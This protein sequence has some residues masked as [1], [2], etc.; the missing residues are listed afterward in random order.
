MEKKD[1][2]VSIKKI[3][4]DLGLSMTTVSRAISGKGRIG[5]RTVARVQEYIEQNALVPNVHAGNQ[6]AAYT[7]TIC[8]ALPLEEDYAELPFFQKILLSIYDFFSACGCRVMLIK[9]TWTDISALQEVVDKRLADGVVLTRTITEGL[10]IKYLQ[11]KKMPFVVTG[12][13]DDE[14][15]LQVDV[16]QM[17]GCYDLTMALLRM[18]IHNMVLF[19]AEKTHVVN[20]SRYKGFQKACEEY[21]LRVAPDMVYDNVG[22]ASVAEDLTLK[23]VRKGAECIL[24]MDDN[25]CMY[26]LKALRKH[27]IEV[28]GDIK[29]ASFY[30]SR[31]L[32]DYYP[33]VSCV[34]FDIKELG[35]V[36]GKLLLDRLNGDMEP[37]R[38]VLGYNIVL[39]ESTK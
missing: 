7:K 19:E 18:G 24:C 35:T 4:E 3:A 9:T 37:K 27:G 34:E 16:D 26:V 36:A 22:Y 32:N 33:S 5:E 39:K 8:V 17:N 15:V 29:V 1:D 10:D 13:Y 21:G 12:S 2:V 25:I 30:N 11:E 20:Q 31:L 6:Q 14:T 28:P 38:I 23:V